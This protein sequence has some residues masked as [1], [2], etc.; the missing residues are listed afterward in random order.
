MATNNQIDSP[1]SG[2]TGTVN[3]AGSTSPTFVTPVLGDATA[4][5]LNFGVSTLNYYGGFNTWVPTISFVTPNDLS[6]AYTTQHGFYSRIGNMVIATCTVTFAPTFTTSAGD[7][8]IDGLPFTS[9]STTG[10][11]AVGSAST[12]SIIF[13]AGYTCIRCQVLA[14]SKFIFPCQIKTAATTTFFAPTNFVTTLTYSITAS[15]LYML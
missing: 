14:N 6:V 2:N 1:L 12:E 8:Y 11:I 7:F 10:N 4:T 3:Y 15:V 9:N 5:S 13:N